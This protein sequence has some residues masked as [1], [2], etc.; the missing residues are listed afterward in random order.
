[1]PVRC[2]TRSLSNSRRGG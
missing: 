2:S 1:M